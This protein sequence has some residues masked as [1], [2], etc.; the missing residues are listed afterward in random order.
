[1]RLAHN[2]LGKEKSK[3][4][5]Q[6]FTV[7]ILLVVKSFMKNLLMTKSSDCKSDLTIYTQHTQNV[8]TNMQNIRK[9]TKHAATTS[10]I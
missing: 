2:T 1:M 6:Y 7:S 9:N 8:N 3:Y 5:W 10:K 4:S